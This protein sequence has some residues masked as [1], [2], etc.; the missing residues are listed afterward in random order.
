MNDSLPKQTRTLMQIA[1]M[2]RIYSAIDHAFTHAS[3][4][5]LMVTSAEPREG[6]TALARRQVQPGFCRRGVTAGLALV[7]SGCDSP[8]RSNAG[9]ENSARPQTPSPPFVRKAA[10]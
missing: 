2:F 4:V 5:S 9:R 1:E 3:P 10:H 6:K 7:L 8:A